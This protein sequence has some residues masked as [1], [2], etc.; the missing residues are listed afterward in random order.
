MSDGVTI[1]IIMGVTALL[2]W[3][4]RPITIPKIF[5][6]ILFIAAIWFIRQVIDFGYNPLE[7]NVPD[8]E[9]NPK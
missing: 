8:V 2:L 9:I 3:A 7:G 4:F 6:A 5:G 1:L